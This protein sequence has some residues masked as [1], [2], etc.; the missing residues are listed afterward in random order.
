MMEEIMQLRIPLKTS[1][2]IGTHWGELK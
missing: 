2:H 1:M